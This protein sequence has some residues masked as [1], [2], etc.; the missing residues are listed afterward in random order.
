[1]AL[2]ITNGIIINNNKRWRTIRVLN[3]EIDLVFEIT[4]DANGYFITTLVDRPEKNPVIIDSGTGIRY[5][6]AIKDAYPEN[7]SYEP[8]LYLDSNDCVDMC[9]MLSDNNNLL[10]DLQTSLTELTLD[11]SE[12][13]VEETSNGWKII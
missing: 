2:A 3:D 6:L 1:M 9:E 10:K 12:I 8:L 13:T 7:V 5:F 11:V 4:Q